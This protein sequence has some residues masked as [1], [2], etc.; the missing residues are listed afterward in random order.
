MAKYTK[1]V[2]PHPVTYWKVDDKSLDVVPVRA[3]AETEQSVWIEFTR[4]FPPSVQPVSKTTTRLYSSW[5][6]AQQA[7]VLALEQR[8]R[9]HERQAIEHR[10]QVHTCDDN[11][12]KVQSM[13]PKPCLTLVANPSFS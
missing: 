13:T 4:R 3:H 12:K 6:D 1:I 8:K 9:F 10:S 7:L 2:F 11:I 5:Y